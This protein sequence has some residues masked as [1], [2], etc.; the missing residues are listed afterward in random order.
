MIK[1]KR[2]VSNFLLLLLVFS[3]ASVLAIGGSQSYAQEIEEVDVI[4]NKLVTLLGSGFDPDDDTLTFL[5]T[6]I[7]GPPVQLSNYEV[8]NPTFM[9]PDVENGKTLTLTFRLT[10]SDPF[11][12]TDTDIVRIIVHPENHPPIADAGRDRILLPNVNAIT[13]FGSGFD[14]DND[15]LFY[16]WEQISGEPVQ[17]FNVHDKSLTIQSLLFDYDYESPLEFELTVTDGFGGSDTDTALVFPFEYGRTN[18]LISVDAGPLQTVNE[19][20]LVTLHV[21]GEN[22]FNAPISYTWSQHLGPGVELSSTFTDSPTFIAPPVPSGG[23]IL[24]SFIV[25]GYAEG[26]GYASD[27]AM[28]KVLST[29]R[30]PI[31]DA[32]L[33]RTVDADSSVTLMGSGSDPDGDKVKYQWK[34]TSGEPV[35]LSSLTTTN[36]IFTAPSVLPEETK[37]LIFE[38]QVSDPFL[39]TSSDLVQI[40]VVSPNHPP[41]ANAGPDQTVDENTP[42]TLEGSGFDQDGDVLTF[43]WRELGLKTTE[44]SSTA[45]ASPSFVAPGVA[46]GQTRTLVFE[47]Q[48]SDPFGLTDTDTVRVIVSPLNAPPTADAGPD[49]TL[50][51]NTLVTLT[52]IGTDPDNDT[53]SYT[54]RQVSG[55]T[56]AFDPLLSTTT[57]VAPEVTTLQQLVFECSVS[58]GGAVATDTVTISVRNALVLDIVADAGPDKIVDE[59]TLIGLDGS[60]SYD[61]EG[62]KLY[63]SWTQISGESVVLSSPSAIKPTFISPIVANYDVKVLEFELRVYDDNGREDTDRVII[64][65]DPINAN[66]EATASAKQD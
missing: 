57:F 39:A 53:L 49:R 40:D 22:T 45:V 4:E 36:P 42:I 60:K 11:G 41:V 19:G 28:V 35:Q 44:L 37:T 29:N 58:D 32:G 13:L 34:Q 17:L 66:P 62:Q 56:V 65:V 9:A 64:T 10:V 30:P 50:D 52:C 12:A 31:A 2:D 33:D 16:S 6:Q 26:A 61:P 20:T 24:L 23:S 18:P 1:E 54:W 3:L 43:S 15:T 7:D 5:W 48:V 8:M 47:L 14:E 38:L 25:T 46:P 21:T 59:E 27:I 55:P 51:E 63:Y